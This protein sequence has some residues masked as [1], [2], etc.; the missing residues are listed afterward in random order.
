MKRRSAESYLN[1]DEA[2]Q[3]DHMNKVISDKRFLLRDWLKA[4]KALI[5]TPFL[6]ETSGVG[7]RVVTA[8]RLNLL[9]NFLRSYKNG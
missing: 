7:K 4:R 8:F 5:C 9:I 1:E 6:H 2:L 3:L